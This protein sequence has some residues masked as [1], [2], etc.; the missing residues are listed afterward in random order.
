MIPE[1]YRNTEGVTV[2]DIKNKGQELAV[3]IKTTR[4]DNS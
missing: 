1:I 3:H 4:G 2:C